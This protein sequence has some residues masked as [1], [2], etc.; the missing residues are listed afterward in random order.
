MENTYLES[1]NL[2]IES[3]EQRIQILKDKNTK[4]EL[5]LQELEQENHKQK[6]DFSSF[7]NINLED[8]LFSEKQLRKLFP[9][10][11]VNQ[12]LREFHDKGEVEVDLSD[13]SYLYS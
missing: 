10:P 9:G 3:I 6:I 2:K 1:P 4:N 12:V 11:I 13:Y 7:L 8:K 5:E